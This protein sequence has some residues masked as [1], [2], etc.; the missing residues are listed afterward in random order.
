MKKTIQVIITGGTIDSL[1]RPSSETAEPAKTSIIPH[2]IDDV[3]KP[4]FKTRYETLCMLDSSRITDALRHKML[5][6]INQSRSQHVLITH[7]TN[8][9]TKTA[10]FLQ[11]QLGADSSKTVVLVGAMVPLKEFALSDG[12]F[13]LGFALG[14]MAALKPGVYIA[15]NGHVFPAGR[16]KKNFKTARFMKA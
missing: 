4:H 16:V 6:L 12:G 7:G 10:A 13:N 3:I 9:M 14:A 8:T 2:Y 15:M 11:K 5:R 1:Y